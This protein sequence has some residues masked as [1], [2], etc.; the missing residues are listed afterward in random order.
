MENAQLR[1]ELDHARVELTGLRAELRQQ[2]V[3]TEEAALLQDAAQRC[4]LTVSGPSLG[5]D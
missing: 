3:V 1:S 4:R 5:A 2:V